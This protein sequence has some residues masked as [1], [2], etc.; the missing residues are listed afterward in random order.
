MMILQN[1]LSKMLKI[2]NDKALSK[3]LLKGLGASSFGQVINI[4]IQLVSVPFLIKFWGI[5]IYGEWIAISAIPQY[6]ALSN[7]GFASVA[8]NIMTMAAA[9]NDE[10]EIVS[11]LQS[12]L[13]L[14]I[15]LTVL[16]FVAV[17]IGINVFDFKQLL[18]IKYHTIETS[19]VIIIALS[20]H[21]LL[22]VFGGL[23]DAIYKA[24]MKLAEFITYI[25]FIRLLEFTVLLA[26]AGTGGS[27]SSAAI[28]YLLTRFFAYILLCVYTLRKCKYVVVG[29]KHAKLDKIKNMLAPSMAFMAVPL[30]N[31]LN[32]QGMTLLVSSFLGPVAVVTFTTGRTISRLAFQVLEQVKVIIWPEISAAFGVGNINLARSLHRSLFSISLWLSLCIMLILI[33]LG[34][35]LLNFWTHNKVVYD[36][37]FMNV[38]FISIIFSA[39][40][41]VS[42]VIQMATNTHAKQAIVYVLA[43]VMAIIFIY[44]YTTNLLTVAV[45]LCFV[46]II[47]MLYVVPASLKMLKDNLISLLYYFFQ[48]PSYLVDAIRKKLVNK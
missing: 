22:S 37:F 14:F 15:F 28:G 24:N 31:M 45:S 12:T 32:I 27:T 5:N 39:V 48:S 34:P 16:V 42:S 6:L 20:A 7:L 38:L 18:Q 23:F 1:L 13:L 10:Q 29:I 2:M 43:N 44:S 35:T 3:R 21:V 19:R 33:P 25:N 30:G 8:G 17:F 47:M 11:T 46:E 9:R 36:S 41:N 4:L 26:I 40:W